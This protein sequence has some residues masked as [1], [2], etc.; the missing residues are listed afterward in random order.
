MKR[1]PLIQLMKEAGVVWPDGANYA[2]QDKRTN[3]VYFHETYPRVNKEDGV[4]IFCDE[5][6]GCHSVE[7]PERCHKWSK[8]IVTKEE[9]AAYNS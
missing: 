9:Y 5:I 4:W 7:L 6:Q 1:K 8:T 2:T 3:I